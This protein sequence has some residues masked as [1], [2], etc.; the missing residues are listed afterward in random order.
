VGGRGTDGGGT[1]AELCVR[2]IWAVACK[3]K[4]GEGRRG[5]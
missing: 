3:T 2:E 5:H 4:S 1:R